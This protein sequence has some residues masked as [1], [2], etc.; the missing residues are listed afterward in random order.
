MEVVLIIFAFILAF[1]GIFIT[2]LS[3]KKVDSIRSNI[4]IKK[5]RDSAC[6]IV[7][8]PEIA[9]IIE[10]LV[11]QQLDFEKQ[12]LEIRSQIGPKETE[13]TEK[14]F[15]DYIAQISSSGLVANSIFYS[16]APPTIESLGLSNTDDSPSINYP[17]S[18]FQL[19]KNILSN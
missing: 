19:A 10:S 6:T 2:N 3:A 14:K 1:A 9:V 18:Q 16:T 11:N 7:E 8:H 4:L 15:I 13:E 17:S 12:L 5:E